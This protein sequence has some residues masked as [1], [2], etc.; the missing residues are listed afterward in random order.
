MFF[1]KLIDFFKGSFGPVLRG[2]KVKDEQTLKYKLDIARVFLKSSKYLRRV[3]LKKLKKTRYEQRRLKHSAITAKECYRIFIRQDTK[4]L[5]K[6]EL[7][8]EQYKQE[9]HELEMSLS[10]A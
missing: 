1:N 2:W 10:K 6:Y 9:I 3:A 8:I 7:C 5:E 4:S